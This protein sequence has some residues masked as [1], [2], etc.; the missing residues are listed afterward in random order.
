MPSRSHRLLVSLSLLL[1]AAVLTAVRAQTAPAPATLPPSAAQ[2][3][4]LANFVVTATRSAV[5]IAD[6]PSRVE[7]I[8][9]SDLAAQPGP[10]VTDTLKKNSSVDVIEYPGG[11]SGIGIRGFRPE[12]SGTNQRTLVLVDGRPAGVSHLGNIPSAALERIEV[13]KGS[14]S[15][16]YGASAMGG[17]VNFIT[18]RST[19][20]I[21][22]SITAGLGS[23]E[24]L[25]ADASLGG[26]IGRFDFD[27][28]AQTRTQFDDFRMGDGRDR[29][30]TS[31]ASHSGFARL[32]FALSPQW[33]IEARAHLLLG[34]D[35]ESPGAYT[36]GTTAQGS[37]ENTL[38]SADI[39]IEGNIDHHQIRATLHGT[40]EYDKARDETAGRNPFRSGIRTTT[41]RGVQLQD[42]WRVL[43]PLTLTFGTDYDYVKTI[44]QTYL[45]TGA[46]TRPTTPDN[47][48][49]TF[50]YFADASAKLFGGA[51]VLNAGARYDSIDTIVR[52][53]PFNSTIFPGTS[54]LTTSNP[55]AGFVWTPLPAWRFHSTAGRAFVSPTANQSAGYE[56]F[57]GTRRLVGRPNPALSAES[58][59]SYDAGLGWEGRWLS[60]DATLF[61]TDVKDK[62]ESILLTNTPLL[63]ETTFVNASTAKSTGLE[64]T[65][66]SDLGRLWSAPAGRWRLTSGYTRLYTRV[67][68]LPAGSSILRNVA[69][70]KLNAAV[71]FTAPALS[72]R[73]SARYVRGMWDQDNSKFFSFT[74]GRGGLFEYPAVVLWDAHVA[75]RV[76]KNQD[77][78]VQADNLFDRYYYE[79]GDWPLQGRAVSLRYRYRF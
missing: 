64:L 28:A 19:G 2:P 55:R 62:I 17:V 45:I 4:A 72:A 42:S 70:E 46:R 34:I 52:A 23:F 1:S 53:T 48:R 69:K 40:G 9:A 41:F 47:A 18:R 16:L 49:E 57:A 66:A 5:L 25:H 68:N 58:A 43:D 15:S 6:V 77:V 54:R 73:L 14:A 29:A 36:D 51:L 11:I 44:Y 50:G 35:S 12:F 65:L 67:Q 8:T 32:G 20:P 76:A 75:W 31:F 79:K 22:G 27:L 60:A 74:N 10:Y 61:Q 26:S 71:I 24:T 3:I 21:H 38:R 56:E 30:N 59:W 13:L 7:V 37:R 78:I 39:R 63:R 33:R